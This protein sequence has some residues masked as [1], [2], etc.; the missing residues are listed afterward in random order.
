MPFPLPVD[1]TFRL[2]V[3]RSWL[4]DVDDRAELGD[5]HGAEVSLLTANRLYLLLPPGRGCPQIEEEILD[6]RVKLEHL[7]T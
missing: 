7:R 3:I 5:I 6:K 4:E 2:E 1:P